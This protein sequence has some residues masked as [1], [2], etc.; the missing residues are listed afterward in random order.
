METQREGWSH[1]RHLQ[2]P[3]TLS[4]GEA[5]DGREG[6]GKETWRNVNGKVF[7][8]EH[9][10]MLLP[11]PFL[12]FVITELVIYPEELCFFPEPPTPSLLN[13]SCLYKD[14]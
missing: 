9:R 10:K 7:S 2:E 5:W 6:T 8:P 14:Q 3:F 4:Q 1:S 12:Q 11:E 13:K